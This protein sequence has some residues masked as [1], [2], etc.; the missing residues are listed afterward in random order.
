[1]GT[2]HSRYIIV[3]VYLVFSLFSIDLNRTNILLMPKSILNLNHITIYTTSTPIL[4][5]FSIAIQRQ[6]ADNRVFPGF[7][8]PEIPIEKC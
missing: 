6:I 3:Y 8:S 2:K 4:F 7:T 5:I 1:M